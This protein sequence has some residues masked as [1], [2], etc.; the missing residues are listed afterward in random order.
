MISWERAFHLLQPIYGEINMIAQQE[1]G[2][3]HHDLCCHN[4]LLPTTGEVNFIDFDYCISDSFCHDIAS[5]LKRILK[6]NTWQT[7][8]VYQVL[9]AYE[10]IRP[11][12]DIEKQAIAGWLLFPQDFWQAGF[13]Y[14]IEGWVPREKIARR[15]HLWI[16]QQVLRKEA[17]QEL[18]QAWHLPDIE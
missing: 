16:E 9:A 11:L 14:Y 7:P 2:F 3:C 5:L 17:Y 1:S 4:L 12:S 15:L 8:L 10:S 13:A 18:F 6:A